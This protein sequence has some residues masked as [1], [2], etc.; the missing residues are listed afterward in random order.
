M[1]VSPP[2]NWGK[3]QGTVRGEPCTGD[4]VP[5]P[6]TVQINLVNDPETG[7]T[8]SADDQGRYA[9]WLPRGRYDV[10]VARD[11]WKPESQRLRISAG[12]V[13]TVDFTLDP[14]HPCG[15]R[16]GGR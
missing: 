6:A 5:V 4:P 1:N 9:L 3:I 10:I 2:P 11:G 14:V 8:L 13:S 7:Y 16:V 15:T 12:L